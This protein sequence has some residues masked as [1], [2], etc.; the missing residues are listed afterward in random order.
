MKMI[1]ESSADEERQTRSEREVAAPYV[2]LNNFLFILHATNLDDGI[3]VCK[4]KCTHK[5]NTTWG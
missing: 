1:W 2:I 3:H 5:K 4:Y